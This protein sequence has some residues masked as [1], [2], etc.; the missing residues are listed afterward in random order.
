MV[1]PGADDPLGKKLCSVGRKWRYI[2]NRRK[3]QNL[4]PVYTNCQPA[5]GKL[6]IGCGTQVRG[7]ICHPA[8][9]LIM[10]Q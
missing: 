7:K 10:S 9:V 8:G 6:F 1:R 5:A 3:T 2:F 4:I